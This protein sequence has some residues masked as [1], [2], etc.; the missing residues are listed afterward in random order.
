LLLG[1][2]QKKNKRICK[3]VEMATQRESLLGCDQKKNK[4]VCK[5]VHESAIVQT[6]WLGT[7]NGFVQDDLLHTIAQ[8]SWEKSGC[9]Q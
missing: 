8:S 2:E 1:F 7:I 9:E 5:F 6:K 3:F 4:K